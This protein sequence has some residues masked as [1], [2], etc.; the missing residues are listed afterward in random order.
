MSNV[1]SKLIK[2]LIS[3][4]RTFKIYLVNKPSQL[5]SDCLHK[6]TSTSG[7]CNLQMAK[8]TKVG[9]MCISVK[10]WC[11]AQHVL[12]IVQPSLTTSVNHPIM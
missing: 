9:Q 2:I 4:N 6:R 10:H 12:Y 1:L 3:F 7:K 5:R 11:S 8:F